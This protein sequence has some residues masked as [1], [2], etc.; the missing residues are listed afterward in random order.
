MDSKQYRAA[1]K[2]LGLNQTEAADM[3]G[4][5]IR[6]SAGYAGGRPIPSAVALALKLMLRLQSALEPEDLRPNL[7][8]LR[9]ILRR[10]REEELM[11]SKVKKRSKK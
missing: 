1:L 5:S 7:L 11:M 9:D 6:S 8:T 2:K 10:E 3:L 4:V